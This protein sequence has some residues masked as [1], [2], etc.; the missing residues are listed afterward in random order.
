MQLFHWR[1]DLVSERRT[2]S[3]H[4][5]DNISLLYQTA[6]FSG[7][8]MKVCRFRGVKSH[9]VLLFIDQITPHLVF[10]ENKTFTGVQNFKGCLFKR[11]L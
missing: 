1:L 7:F 8:E 4:E 3:C 9:S 6:F 11:E 10:Q 5:L 2:S